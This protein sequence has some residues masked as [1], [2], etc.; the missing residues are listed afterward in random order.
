M[1][2]FFNILVVL[3]VALMFVNCQNKKVETTQSTSGLK[4]IYFDYD[5]SYIRTDAALGLQG[6]ASYL[7][8]N[9]SSSVVI[10]G[11]CD[12]RG[13]N[14]YNLALGQRRAD[15]SRDY[16]ANLGVERSRMRTSSYGEEKPVCYQNEESCWQRNRRADFRQ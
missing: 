8:Q 10:E 4:T 7:K 3:F 9:T 5:R 16:L 2:N 1:R 11:H 6:N 13:T 12:N 14:E 15:A